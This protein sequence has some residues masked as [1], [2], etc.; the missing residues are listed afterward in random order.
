MGPSRPCLAGHARGLDRRAGPLHSAVLGPAARAL[1]PRVPA[2]EPGARG[3]DR[4]ARPAHGAPLHLRARRGR[5]A[6][7]RPPDLPGRERRGNG[8]ARHRRVRRARAASSRV[9]ATLAAAALRDG[10]HHAGGGGAARRRERGIGRLLRRVHPGSRAG[11]RR[12]G[13]RAQDPIRQ[14][15]HRPGADAPDG[16]SGARGERHRGRTRQ[17]AGGSG[18]TAPGATREP[19]SPYL[20]RAEPRPL[21]RPH[22]A[23]ERGVVPG[24]GIVPGIQAP[25]RGEGRAVAGLPAA[26]QVLAP[27]Q[28]WRVAE[29]R[30]MAAE[31]R[32]RRAGRVSLGGRAAQCHPDAAAHEEAAHLLRR[33][34]SPLGR[35][36]GDG[37]L[38]P[39]PVDDQFPAGP[40]LRSRPRRP[41]RSGWM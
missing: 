35:R 13:G 16:P 17:R 15:V 29:S 5:E 22:R 26:G 33:G 41:A 20:V 39:E 30:A 36:P 37:L 25:S 4:A 3:G 31:S 14:G 8:G 2:A 10:T 38:R 6:R 12:H 19:G 23:V 11:R 34:D 28:A 24:S 27:D 9:R 7:D 21:R 40:R 32:G 18:G 1:P